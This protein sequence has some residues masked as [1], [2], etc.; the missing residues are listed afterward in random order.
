MRRVGEEDAI[1]RVAGE[2]E[3]GFCRSKET[4]SDGPNVASRHGDDSSCARC[5]RRRI[6]WNGNECEDK[7]DAYSIKHVRWGAGMVGG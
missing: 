6:G 4:A 3:S 1:E 2:R 7:T 5:A